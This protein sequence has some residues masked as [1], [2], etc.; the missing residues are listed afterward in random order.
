MRLGHLAVATLL[1]VSG[2]WATLA[3]AAVIAV[4]TT[5]DGVNADGLCGLREAVIAA[6]TDAAVDGCEAGSGSDT[7]TIPAGTYVLNGGG[8]DDDEA[9]TDDLDVTDGVELIGAGAGVT[10]LDGNDRTRVL[11]LDPELVGIDV[12]L[13]GLAVVRG[14]PAGLA[15]MGGGI[16]S[17]AALAIF[18][19]DIRDNVALSAA[20]PNWGGGGIM[21]IGESTTIERTTIRDN[22]ANWGGGIHCAAGTLVVRDST[23]SGNVTRPGG[24]G[25][26]I[27]AGA[28]VIENS[29]ISGNDARHETAPSHAGGLRIAS[30]TIRGS[31]IS[32]NLAMELSGMTV[33]GT[34]AIV[35]T[36]ISNNAIAVGAGSVIANSTL[37]GSFL[38]VPDGPEPIDL[39][40]RNSV[41]ETC[42]AGLFPSFGTI[43]GDAHNLGTTTTCGLSGTD[44]VGVDPMLGPL[45]MNGGETATHAPLPGSPL[46]N[47]GDAAAPGSGGMACE[48]DDQRG[49]GRPQGGRCDIGAVEVTPCALQPRAD[50]STAPARKSRLDIKDAASD[51][52]DRLVWSWRGPGVV[53][54]DF[55]DPTSATDVAVCLYD[56]TRRLRPS[57]FAPAG[58]ICGGKPCW[59]ETATGFVFRNRTPS[60]GR[61]KTLT[62]RSGSKAKIGVLGRGGAALVPAPPRLAPII[63]QI[64]GG[65]DGRCWDAVFSA[66][67]INQPGILRATSD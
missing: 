30:G 21:C 58:G 8:S 29:T 51:E 1:C 53:E 52:Q 34:L 24:G 26:G 45:Q 25:A 54:S 59:R 65:D 49:A 66:P 60:A 13:R 57:L 47:A 20:A 32:D 7:I 50:C 40:V 16:R 61:P 35:N 22:V 10:T 62:L 39:V 56:G 4:E 42:G 15:T 5:V 44:L 11:D 31:T 9:A 43:S 37:R 27:W 28:V 55:G 2:P 46:L 64:V 33:S 17:A 36:T 18:D 38:A 63:V 23:V 48:P 6:N 67:A 3:G 41:L 12:V 14:R 19:C